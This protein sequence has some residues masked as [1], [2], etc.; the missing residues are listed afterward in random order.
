MISSTNLDEQIDRHFDATAMIAACQEVVRTPSL[1]GQESNVATV[2][3]RHLRSLKFDEVEIDSNGNVIARLRGAGDGPS[4]MVN[5]HMDHVPTGAM[6]APF[7]GEVVEGTQWGEPGPAIFGRGTC[8]MKCNVM[9]SA[10]AIA[11][12][13][14]AG[15]ALRG[16]VVFVADVQEEIDSPAG[17]KSVIERGVRTDF[18]LSTES[19]E[20]RAYVGH[21]GKLEFEVIVH[22]RTSHAAQP[23]RGVNAIFQSLPLLREIESL[24][25]SLPSDPLL[26]DAT[27]TIT[28]LR[29]SP[30]NSTAV[31]PD[32]CHLRIDRRYVRGETPQKCEDEL[33]R[34][35]AGIGAK[36][37][38]FRAD[39]RLTNHY[40]L[41]Y[42]DPGARVV[43]AAQEAIEDAARADGEKNAWRSVAAEVGAWRFGVNGTFMCEA[44]IPTVGVGPGNEKWAH[45]PQEHVGLAQLKQACRIWTRMIVRVCGVAAA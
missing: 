17:V 3:E 40:P 12:I 25:A 4:L 28:G 14:H 38:G 41:M 16:D 45:T 22:G 34:L 39:L 24:G 29:S 43:Q 35:L 9:A 6:V 19:T 30:D 42:V 1:S 21:R 18:G 13:R 23:E 44:G 2:F 37:S 10:F 36:G 27:V 5:G 26:G 8:D 32:A 11:A 20:C 7:S 31:I 33:R 15:V